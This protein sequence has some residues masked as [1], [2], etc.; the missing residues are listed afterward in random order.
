MRG[1]RRG[2]LT[3]AHDLADGGLALAVVE[4]ALRH[5]MGAR[6]KLPAKPDPFIWL[7]SEST[8]RILVSVKRG[9]ERDLATLCQ[10]NGVKL[11]RLGEITDSEDATLELVDQFTL[12]LTRILQAWRSTLP[13]AMAH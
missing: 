11:T 7:F 9:T 6:I 5:G 13:A 10:T 1:S 3:S 4:S 8:G 2:L 12:P